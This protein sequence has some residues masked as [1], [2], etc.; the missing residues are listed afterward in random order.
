VS[1]ALGE[2]NAVA[3]S[4]FLVFILL[5]LAIT[6]WAARRT[7][8][9]DH[10]YAAGRT[11]TARQNGLALAGDF[12]S[13]AAFLGNSG[14]IA[15]SGFDGFI[16]CV[17]GIAGWPIVMVLVAEAL[18]KLGKYTF[19]DVVAYRLRQRPVRIV[20]AL[21]SLTV[22]LFYLTVQMVGAGNL[23]RFLF[24]LSY[25]SAVAIVG[26]VMLAAVLF[27]GMIATTWVQI[28]K[29]VLLLGG[30]SILSGLALARF[31]FSPLA[32]FDAAAERYGPPVL[33]PGG[34]LS[35]PF[36]AVSLGLALMLGT[37]GLP[38][39]LM[40]FYTVR[41]ARTARVSVAYATCAIGFFYLLTYVLGY[42]A[43]AI[44]GRE[45]IVSVD[46]GGNMAAPLLA[47]MVGGRPFMGFISAVAFSTILAVVAGLT[48]SGAATLSHDLWVHVVRGGQAVQREQLLVGRVASIAI[49]ILAIGLGIAFKGQNVS[50][51]VGLAFAVAAGANFP[52]L[53]LAIYWKRLTTAGAIASM[54]VGTFV[55]VALIVLSPAIQV[56]ILGYGSAPFPLRNPA[57]V[58]VPLS[59]A[60]AILVSLLAPNRSEEERFGELQH[61]LHLAA[62]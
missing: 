41:D 4:F 13:A 26:A 37:A 29:A 42:G 24:G 44:V 40:R 25:E 15:L 1:T 5:A 33:A 56:D 14:L 51:M 60:V 43:M 3:I 45:G 34:L 21:G 50:Y 52:A 46:P 39:I 18:R 38:H 55:T 8:S 32:L 47:E 22:V 54:L 58:T 19:V 53:V 2:P 23:I 59:F 20:A 12:M 36:D 27:G 28:I 7:R 11:V 49:A 10:F 57:I 6:V 35:D 9:T 31:G 48:L 61:R 16:Y 17:G 62:E 30:A